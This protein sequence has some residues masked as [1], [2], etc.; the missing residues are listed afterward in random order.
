MGRLISPFHIL[1]AALSAFSFFPA[2]GAPEEF[3]SQDDIMRDETMIV[4]GL[5]SNGIVIGEDIEAVIRRFGKQN[6]RIS[7][8]RQVNELF[9]NVFKI[10]SD[11]K[12]YFDSLYYY[13]GRKYAA[14]VFQGKVIA[15]IGFDANCVTKDA[16]NLQSGI[17]NFIYNYGNKNLKVLR[18]GTN[19]MYVYSA[20]G[21][22]LADDDMNDTIDLF[23]VFVP[24]IGKKN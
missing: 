11:T 2:A 1:I 20:L 19:G 24:P 22:A 9:N 10:A 3:G 12:I 7:R 23:V 6:F 18:S 5:G 13:D 15:V 21:I 16:V 14:C 4:P 17:S 8:P